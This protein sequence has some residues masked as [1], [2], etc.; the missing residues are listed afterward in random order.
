[1]NITQKFNRLNGKYNRVD[2]EKL[3]TEAMQQ[4]QTEVVKR[5][6]FILSQYPNAEFFTIEVDEPAIE[7]IEKNM[8]G[9]FVCDDIN[10]GEQESLGK[11]V[12]A[13][14]IYDT[15]TE[16]ILNTIKQVGH[17][18]WQKEWTGSSANAAKNYVTK[19]AYTGINYLVL[20]FD[21]KLDDKGN[22]YLVPIKFKQPYYLTFKQIEDA[23]AK[24]RK[25]AHS[26]QAFY[27]TTLLCFKKGD[28]AI[29]TTDK[30]KFAEFLKENNI[31]KSDQEEFGFFI[32]IPKYYRVFRAD[33]CTGLKF[34]KTP[35]RKKIEPIDAA[36][37]V[38][39]CYPE[40]PKF[41]F[42]GDQAVY[43]PK[44]DTVNMPEIALFDKPASYYSTFFHEIV[45]STGHSKRLDR[46]N[47]SRTRDGGRKDKS[48]YAF[49][50]LIAELGAVYLSAEAGILFS[51]RENSAKYLASWNKR[52]V[53][54]LNKDNK[55]IFKAAAAAQKA[56]D[57]ILNKDTE[58]VP[59][60]YSS[61]FIE[62]N[63]VGYM[64]IDSISGELVASKKTLPELEKVYYDLDL[65]KIG[66]KINT[67]FVYQ[68]LL[69]RH[70][71]NVQG[72]RIFVGW[73]KPTTKKTP[74]V[75]SKKTK[76]NDLSALN[77]PDIV[78]E[79]VP[80]TEIIVYEPVVCEPVASIAPVV[81]TI[82]AAK[83]TPAETIPPPT[84]SDIPE[85]PVYE[86]EVIQN[87][88]LMNTEFDSLQMDDG[89][90][91]FMQEPAANLKVA[92]YGFPKNGKTSGALQFAEYLTKFGNVLY[93]F[94]DQGFNKNTQDLWKNSGLAYNSKAEPSK[95]ST[96][97]ELEAKIKTGKY[98]YIFIDM[99]NNYIF[100]EKIKPH[101]FEDRF[102]KRYPNVSFILIFEV[103]KNGNF[104]G[105]E[106]WMHV[107]DSIVTVSNFLME[108]RGRYG[109][110]YKVIWEEGFKKFAPKK[111]EELFGNAI[112]DCEVTETINI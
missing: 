2:I 18:P 66:T 67:V 76:K 12:S 29:R 69:D 75:Q 50:E 91:E 30:E 108:N 95:I 20:N 110:G 9:C 77:S 16:L 44:L 54:L 71:K 70:G 51:T 43:Y 82:P 27:Y 62:N 8:L 99:I 80:V 47:D 74:A 6:Q 28:L 17:L 42:N 90:E 86:P 59:A 103:V 87:N 3:L 107:V 19:K 52:L 39:D 48:D 78:I 98:Q 92:F 4:H 55:A 13:N 31:S 60:F 100:R 106:A 38:I 41:T 109:S 58:G 79:D 94:V 97:D 7:G 36:Q 5:L 37:A 15:V 34:G 23:G 32:P 10:E 49:E 105:D 46:G 73:K 111:Y 102:I 101:E 89:W 53:E 81:T 72:D 35:E 25:G 64:L 57:Y 45:H 11:S 84:V 83:T 56:A 21:I 22:P 24:L 26:R 85:I 96:L 112:S 14:D 40:P 88:D 61:K 104:R 93:N 68:V 65:K 33:D 63:I 1:M